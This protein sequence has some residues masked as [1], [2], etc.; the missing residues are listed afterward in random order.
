MALV[1]DEALERSSVVA[2][3]AMNRERGLSGSN[4]Y[5]REL[6]LDPLAELLGRLA[7]T[8][9][10]VRWLD[11]C[12]GSGRALF[13]AAE[14]LAA[15]GL[16]DRVRIVG[17][18]LVDHFVPGSGVDLVTASVTG[19]AP[20]AGQVFDLVTCV[21]GLHYVG[22]KLLALRR[23]ASWLAADG[24]FAASFDA[25]SV[26][27]EAGAPVGRRLTAAL[28]SAG[29]GYDTRNRRI[30]RRGRA[31]VTLPFAYLGADD[32]AG[33]NYTGQPAVHSHYV[34]TATGSGP[35]ASRTATALNPQAALPDQPAQVPGR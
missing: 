7:R 24:V 15:T 28:R 30:T 1:R 32:A 13:Q 25:T 29:F 5:A 18:D 23:A 33:P 26:R 19:W 17:V 2:N 3:C 10:P 11:L 27:D 20:P 14:R 9:G 21:H 31:D 6:G 22:D 35:S 12:C 16:A 34:S 4:G 8:T